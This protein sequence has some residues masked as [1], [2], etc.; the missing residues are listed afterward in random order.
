MIAIKLVSV[1]KIT[2]LL[3]GVNYE[4]CSLLKQLYSF[5]EV[6]GF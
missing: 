4:I 5:C 2:C 1:G 6:F 3:R